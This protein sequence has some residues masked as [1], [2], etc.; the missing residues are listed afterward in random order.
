MKRRFETEKKTNLDGDGGVVNLLDKSSSGF[1][2]KLNSIFYIFC[3]L[4]LHLGWTL[5]RKYFFSAIMISTTLI[6]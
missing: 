4:Y 3:A 1:V 6:K 5:F 2:A